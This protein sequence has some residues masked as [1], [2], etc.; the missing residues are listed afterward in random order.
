[1]QL[2]PVFVE[3]SSIPRENKELLVKFDNNVEKI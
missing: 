1:M 3:S 2:L